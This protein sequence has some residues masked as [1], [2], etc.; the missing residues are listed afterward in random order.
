MQFEQMRKFSHESLIALVTTL[1]IV[2]H[3][4]L[5]FAFKTDAVLFNLPLYLVY[6][7]GGAF[8]VFNLTLGLFKGQFGSDIL[9]G[10]AI[11]V[12]FLL[13]EYVAGALVILMLSGGE[14]LERYAVGKASSVLAAL[15]KRVP[16]TAH[17]ISNDSV[18][19]IKIEEIQIGDELVV[20]PHEACP[21][22]G[23]V[24]EGQGNMDESYLTG[25]PFEMSKAPG[26][27]VY[28]GAI[29]SENKLVIQAS[30]LAIDSRFA[31]I[32]K[33]LEA[34]EASRPHMRRLGDK[35]GAWYTP[36]ALL[37][38]GI[39]GLVS[40]EAERFLA[41]LV[42]ATPCPLL[43]AIPVAVIGSISLAAKRSIIIK[44]PV[45]L[46]QVDQ[47]RTIILDKTGTLTSGKPH[48]TE[49]LCHKDFNDQEVLQLVASIEKYSKH[50]LSLAINEA[51]RKQGIKLLPVREMS[52]KPGQG[53]LAYVNDTKVQI[54]SRTKLEMINR[55]LAI[56]LP[57]S[58]AG[59]ECVILVNDKYAATYRFRDTARRDSS[60]F[61]NHLRTRHNFT[62]V[63]LVS[64][65]RESEVRYLAEQVGIDQ[66]YA[67]QSPEQ[68]V[69][70]VKEEMKHAKTLFIGD[71]IN[72]APALVLATVG[73][74]FGTGSEVTSEAADAVIMHSSLS[75]VDEFFHI[76]RRMRLIALQSA[77][78]GMALSV[79]GMMFAA[80]GYLS[81][82]LG[83][84]AQEVIDLLSVINA[85][86]VAV[87]QKRLSDLSEPG[88]R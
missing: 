19:E 10:I 33:V 25:E 64:G 66:I 27:T 30:K 78:G 12:S 77:V 88:G 74:A 47:C 18:T 36:L 73:I 28:S 4:L 79:F 52:E 63:M 6:A 15:A 62:K 22:D 38:A 2:A 67:E 43:I 48:L 29:N 1:A 54:T 7:T 84:I 56:D 32:M 61:I 55:D 11:V 21:V 23:I 70:I 13:G 80:A 50:P 45:A 44:N 86:R 85:L 26:S 40:G 39:A 35:L 68:K 81:P 37:I 51:A 57:Q 87:P 5:R 82:V 65:D 69:E 83:A 49:R 71:G 20:F 58:K 42:I 17:K 41:V 3:L 75:K 9:A 72:D 31:K 60:F 8:L 76:S 14:A 34:S 59:L 24:I 46:E 16:A 53:L